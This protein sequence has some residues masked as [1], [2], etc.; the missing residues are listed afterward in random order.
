M[1]HIFNRIKRLKISLRYLTFYK[2]INFSRLS[3]AYLLSYLGIQKLN[4]MK[5]GFISI[6]TA[7]Y[8]NLN[9]PECP[10]GQREPGKLD[11]LRFDL[12]LYKKTIDELK[13]TLQHVILYFQGEPLLNRQLADFIEYAHKAGVYT[14]TST[15]AQLLYE[16]TAKELVLSGLDKLII[17]ADGSTQETYETYRVGGQLEK[18]LDGIRHVVRWKCEFKSVTPLIE[19]QFIVLKTNEHQMEDM[20]QIAKMLKVDRLTFKTAQLY[21]YEDG[22]KLLTTKSKYARYKLLPNGKYHLKGK[23]PN[24]CWRLWNGAVVNAKGD[25]LPCCFDKESEFSF[26]NI[27]EKS[28]AEAWHT[29]NASDF[30]AKILQNRK[31]FEM[32]RNCTSR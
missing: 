11:R 32:C 1:Q 18:A 31:K 27:N 17:S 2:I 12:D 7:N 16:T 14:S 6:E 29:K 4:G 9:C 5:P 3:F 30:R 24:R 15:N 21:N 8:C 10:V 28:F 20:K 22:N 25:V 19:L 23:Q 13:S 26:G